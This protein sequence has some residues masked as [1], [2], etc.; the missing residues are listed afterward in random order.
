MVS[1]RSNQADPCRFRHQDSHIQSVPFKVGQELQGKRGVVPSVQFDYGIKDLPVLV[2]TGRSA[3]LRDFHSRKRGQP[4]LSWLGPR[5]R[6]RRN[7]HCE[8]QLVDLA[9]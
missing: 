8:F 7:W 5:G 6:R 1:E 9:P 2:P 3:E 4:G